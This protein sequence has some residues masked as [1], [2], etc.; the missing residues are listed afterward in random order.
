MA[1]HITKTA[2]TIITTPLHKQKYFEVNLLRIALSISHLWKHNIGK[3][4]SNQIVNNIENSNENCET[5]Y[6]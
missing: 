2:E 5:N 1:N 3:Y 4:L 6:I